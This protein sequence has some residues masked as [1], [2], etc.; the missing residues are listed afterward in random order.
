VRGVQLDGETRC[1]HWHGATDIVAIKFRC[2]GEYFA[3]HECHVALAGHPA[4][5]WPRA[6][7]HSPAVRCGVC[8]NEQSITA[9]LAD[10]TA[11]PVCHAEFNPRCAPHHTLYFQH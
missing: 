4:E 11:C 10:H 3:C 1:A 9:Y 6:E 8:G 7:F 5:V 2:C